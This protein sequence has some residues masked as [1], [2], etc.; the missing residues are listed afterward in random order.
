MNCLFFQDGNVFFN[1]PKQFLQNDQFSYNVLTL[2]HTVDGSEI[3][4]KLVGMNKTS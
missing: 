4:E 2:A 3:L 1:I